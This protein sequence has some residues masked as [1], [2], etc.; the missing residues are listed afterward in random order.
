M[1]SNRVLNETKRRFID[2]I[3]RQ[4]TASLPSTNK[5]KDVYVCNCASVGACVHKTN[6]FKRD[7]ACA[8]RAALCLLTLHI[9]LFNDDAV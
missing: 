2:T 3:G 9:N 4:R 8:T 1:G 5:N 7:I 6:V